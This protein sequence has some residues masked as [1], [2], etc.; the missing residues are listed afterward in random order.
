MGVSILI[1]WMSPFLILGVV[2]DVFI[3]I[4]FCLEISFTFNGVDP[5]TAPRSV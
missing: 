5:D 2:L 3:F 1:V 4:V